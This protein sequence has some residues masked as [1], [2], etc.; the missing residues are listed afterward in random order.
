M[1]AEE[2]AKFFNERHRA[3]R[4]DSECEWVAGDNCIR[5]VNRGDGQLLEGYSLRCAIEVMNKLKGNNQ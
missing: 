2:V 4:P 1:T 3:D 5:F